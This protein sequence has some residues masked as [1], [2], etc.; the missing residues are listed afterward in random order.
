MI[1]RSNGRKAQLGNSML[2]Q[3]LEHSLERGPDPLGARNRRDRVRGTVRIAG[4]HLQQC[5]ANVRIHVLLSLEFSVEIT[6]LDVQRFYQPRTCLTVEGGPPAVLYQCRGRQPIS[7]RQGSGEN[8]RSGLLLTAADL[9][10]TVCGSTP[11]TWPA[12]SIAM[13]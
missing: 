3:T 12:R 6:F 13:R 2:R 9:L 1:A 7:A 10:A 5:R 8:A 11:A 4:R